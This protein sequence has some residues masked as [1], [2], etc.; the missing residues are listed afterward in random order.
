MDEA[1]VTRGVGFLRSFIEDHR[2]NYPT[3]A[4][5]QQTLLRHRYTAKVALYNIIDRQLE[6]GREYRIRIDKECSER[7]IPKPPFNYEIA[8]SATVYLVKE[9][10]CE[11]GDVL[12]PDHFGNLPDKTYLSKD[13]RMYQFR[14]GWER[15][16]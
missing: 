7:T 16:L 9:E 1:V 2:L 14:H 5:W 8:L 12:H 13:N 11:V 15:V 6:D 3:E 4:I 10:E